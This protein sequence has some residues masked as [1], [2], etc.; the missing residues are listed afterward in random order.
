[1][2]L[3]TGRSRQAALAV[4][5]AL[6]SCASDPAAE[7]VNKE[8]QPAGG[9]P[10]SEKKSAKRQ[11]EEDRLREQR[12][13]SYQLGLTDKDIAGWADVATERPQ[14]RSNWQHLASLHMG[15]ARLSGDYGDYAKAEAHLEKAFS[16][17][18]GFGPWM[19]RARLNYAL[20]RLDRV[21]EDYGRA[22][23][24]APL[25]NNDKKAGFL[26]FQAN[27]DFQRGNYKEAR[28]L[29]H[30]ALALSRPVALSSYAVF[31]WK[32]GAFEE[33]ET[34][35]LEANKN[36]HG[37]STEPV[38]WTH[39]QLGLMDLDRGRYEDALAHY[40][41]AMKY[42]AGY[43][44]ID[45][46]IAEILTLQGKPEEAKKLYLGIIERT[47][48]P[49]FMD[50]M[51]RIFREEGNEA[52]AKK[53]IE[54]ARTRY[55]QQLEQFP[56]AAY[57]HALGHFLEFGEDPAQ[58]VELAEKNHTLRPN[59][60]AKTLL[61]Q[62]YL[63]AARPKDALRIIEQAL[64]TP[65]VSANLYATAAQT[66]DATGDRQRSDQNLELATSVDPTVEADWREV[67]ETAEPLATQR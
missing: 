22:V 15:R 65:A 2:R 52:E 25:A 38:A 26:S 35:F 27:I 64:E 32:T 43:W 60:E 3:V 9:D 41:E 7:P 37:K 29:H 44:L 46:H 45:E 62:A 67:T 33:A 23:S 31:L 30:E 48:S 40:N 18:P 55:D 39:L 21:D 14:S 13:F 66:Y 36:Y 53:Y 50:A 12:T 1:M 51:A 24:G 10:K 42:I 56:E 58:V 49:E 11:A 19:T 8:K 17:K 59:S 34:L 6:A 16:V 5:F 47:N 28:K 4:L 63:K 57:G 61:A 54:R 20:H